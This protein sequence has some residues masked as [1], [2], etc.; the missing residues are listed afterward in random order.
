MKLLLAFTKYRRSLMWV[1]GECQVCR[2]QRSGQTQVTTGDAMFQ[3]FLHWVNITLEK[4]NSAD[5]HGCSM[6]RKKKIKYMH[7]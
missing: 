3:I 7:E 1:L 2:S 6:S 5:H 4:K